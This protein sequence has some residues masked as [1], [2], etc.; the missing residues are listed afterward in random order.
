MS[1]TQKDASEKAFQE[2]FVQELTKYKW[3]A[4]PELNGNI[5]KVTV[6]TLIENWRNELNRLNKDKL[7]GVELTDNEFKQVMAKVCQIKNSY[8]AA[9]ILAA[10]NGKGKIDGIYRDANPKVT[11]KQITLTIFHKADVIGGDSHYQIAR[12]VWSD[13]NNRFDIVLLFCGLPLINIELKRADKS[14]DLAWE[15]FQRYYEAGEYVNNFMAF[16]QMMVMSSEVATKYFATPKNLA[17][18]KKEFAFHWSDAKNN[19]INGWQ[20]ICKHFLYIPMAHQ[21]VGDYLVINEGDT[22][23]DR[24]HMVMRPY[25]VYALQAIE[26]AAAGKD[27]SADGIPHGGFTWHTTGSGKTITSYKTALFLSTRAGFDKII[28]MV[29]RRELDANTSRRFNAYSAYESVTVDD[30]DFTYQLKQKIKAPGNGIVVTT[31]FKLNNLVKELIENKDTSLDNKR[32]VFI[33]DEAHRTTMGGMMVNIT[34]FFKKNGLFFG[35]TGTPLFTENNA[36]GMKRNT[37]DAN[38]NIIAEEIDTTEKLFGPLL[39]SYTIDEAIRDRNV[40]GFHVE[41]MNTGEFK[42]YDDLRDKI[43]TQLM[44]EDDKLTKHEAQSKAAAMS[45]L[46]L[47][48]KAKEYGLIKYSD[49]KHIPQV[50]KDILENWEHQS[51]NRNFNSILTVGRIDRAIDYLEEFNNQQVGNPNPINIAVTISFATEE[52]KKKT[53]AE[54]AKKVFEQYEKFTGQKFLFG[55]A[56]K[57]NNEEAY[58][59]D[60]IYRLARGGSG[61]NDKNIDLVIVAD[62]LLTGYDSKYLNTL[63]V[64][65]SLELQGLVQA[66]SRTNRLYGPEKE[67]GTIINYQWPAITEEAVNKALK[68]YGSGGSNSPAIVDTYE[69]AVEKMNVLLKKVEEIL[70]D[71]AQWADLKTDEAKMSAFEDA[72]K[73]AAAQMTKVS[74]YYEAVWDKNKFACSQASWDNY[75]GAYKNLF[76]G[77]KIPQP[78]FIPGKLEGDIK[79]EN[80]I[81]VNAPYIL[82]L[83][84][85][86][87]SANGTTLSIDNESIRLI[88]EKIQD[89]SNKG[90]ATQAELLKAF[91][92]DIHAGKIPSN[93]TADLAFAKWKEDKFSTVIETFANDWGCDVGLL[94]I[95]IQTYNPQK[96]EDIPRLDELIESVNPDAAQ[97]KFD[98]P[99]ELNMAF[100]DAIEVWMK[101][102]KRIYLEE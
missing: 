86:K 12:E 8:E 61:R 15:Q 44:A 56:D 2:K 88:L 87:V 83:I 50:V 75:T 10:E 99:L 29:D 42:S 95:S 4:T 92:D 73:K 17:S 79:V 65:R 34:T 48:K 62:Q 100:T 72:Y 9:K 52:D 53:S 24:Y 31:T 45:K 66:Y 89:F 32:F 21:M 81:T 35:F 67:F 47:E 13:N 39:H 6:H 41:F 18:F 3:E 1:N 28:F 23:D 27:S 80:V 19:I 38:G 43:V 63:Y 14:L 26:L 64:D 84:G 51:Q 57:K 46:E 77:K 82:D 101:E 85:K 98:S 74:Q 93:V 78:P 71:P 36:T 25:Q 30:T 20:E 55:S 70:P 54:Q 37:V 90:N 96:G 58:F 16:S 102:T 59:Q 76:P 33:I 91:V 11:Q 68:L 60:L 97:K 7:E 40:L 49:D 5:H 22:E 69:V 94:A